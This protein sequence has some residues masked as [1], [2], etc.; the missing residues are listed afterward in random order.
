M[1]S[2]LS[3]GWDDDCKREAVNIA[4]LII[5]VQAELGTVIRCWHC[6]AR[7]REKG[8]DK[9]SPIHIQTRMN[10]LTQGLPR[11]LI[12]QTIIAASGSKCLCRSIACSDHQRA[13]KHTD[14]EYGLIRDAETGKIP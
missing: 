10:S 12:D 9:G 14:T 2:R 1:K 13:V 11:S 6:P 4:A 3:P 7:C 8:I 5:A